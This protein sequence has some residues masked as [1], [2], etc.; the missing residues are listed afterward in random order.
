MRKHDVYQSIEPKTDMLLSRLHGVRNTGA[1]KWQAKCPSH[2]DRSPSLG[3][4][5]V[6]DK[7]MINC[8]AGCGKQEILSAIG[9][10]FDDLFPDRITDNTKPVP[11]FSR[12]EFYDIAVNEAGII[13]LALMDVLAKREVSVDNW[14][15]VLIA[16]KK[17]SSMREEICRK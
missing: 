15:R 14:D 6:D 3:I 5:Q 2:A 16:I 13:S 12:S 17:I 8:L 11:R 1:G 9:L 10:T 7:I 4:K